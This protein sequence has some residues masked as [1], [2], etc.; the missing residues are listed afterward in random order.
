[1]L[2]NR[3][4]HSGWV[5]YTDPAGNTQPEDYRVVVI[6]QRSGEILY[7]SV[8]ALPGNLR[9]YPFD[10][11]PGDPRLERLAREVDANVIAPLDS[12]QRQKGA[13]AAQPSP[14]EPAPSAPEP[15]PE[16][17]AASA[18]PP[19]VSATPE[20]SREP[21]ANVPALVEGPNSSLTGITVVERKGDRLTLEFAPANLLQKGDRLYLREPPKVIALPGMD[22]N[23]MTAGEI[24]GL[25]EI[26][27]AKDGSATAKRLSGTIP[28][29]M[30][31]E[32]AEQP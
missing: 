17:A 6:R 21:Q 32:R 25:I 19:A 22:E 29:Q 7:D 31:F 14:P 9:A 20:P 16:P 8:V 23:L 28:D 10:M 1:V 12:Y 3:A 4:D 5:G 15:A 18:T 27:R 26:T 2:L 24:S 13:G 30:Y 11:E